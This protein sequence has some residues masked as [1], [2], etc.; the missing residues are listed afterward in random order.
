MFNV[1]NTGGYRKFNV[2]FQKVWLAHRPVGTPGLNCARIR[3]ANGKID[4]MS[5]LSRIINLFSEDV[6]KF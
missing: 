2:I 6:A 3:P 1:F 5:C 4:R